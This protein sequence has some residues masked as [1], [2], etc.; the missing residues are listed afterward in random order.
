MSEVKKE[1]K[2]T[3]KGF[4]HK[5]GSSKV[6]AI[7]FL[8]AH[9]EYLTNGT[10]G[11]MVSPIIAKVDSQELMPTP[12]LTQIRKLVLNHLVAREILEA[13]RKMNAPP[14]TRKST[15]PY[16]ATVYTKDG[17]I[18]IKVNDEGE[19]KDLVQGFDDAVTAEGW[20]D[21]RL[22]EGENGWFGQIVNETTAYTTNV[23]R[24]DS[25]A[26]VYKR[27]KKPVMHRQ[28]KSTGSLSFGVK[29]HNDHFHV[30]KG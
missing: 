20:I 19:E 21:R 2:M 15:K 27:P 1:R 7:A 25:F 17:D 9:R 24:D 22:V 26:R 8:A 29:V 16:R 6:S 4:L 18:A 14:G 30:S 28:A 23:D 3:E 12:A 5:S 10:I 13:E 11:Q